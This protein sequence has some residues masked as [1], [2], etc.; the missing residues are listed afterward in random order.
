MSKLQIKPRSETI[1]IDG[2]S[3]RVRELTAGE[4]REIGRL[5]RTDE[6]AIATYC[7]KQCVVDEQGSPMFADDG[8]VEALPGRVLKR[9][10]DKI[11]ELSGFAAGE[12]GGP[13]GPK[14]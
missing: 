13:E 5:K 8:E 3:V 14:S 12:P 11:A 4:V 1:E 10:N 9:I 7:I 6:E 2:Q